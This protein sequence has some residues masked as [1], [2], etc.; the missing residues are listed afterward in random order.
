[1]EEGR[2]M[3]EGGPEAVLKEWNVSSRKQSAMS[4]ARCLRQNVSSSARVG[5]SPSPGTQ[6]ML[7]RSTCSRRSTPTPLPGIAAVSKAPDAPVERLRGCSTVPSCPPATGAGDDVS[8][9]G[10]AGGPITVALMKEDWLL[11]TL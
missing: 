8:A 10:L 2:V 1:M 9:G 3:C 6:S 5:G 4:I 11:F 7:N